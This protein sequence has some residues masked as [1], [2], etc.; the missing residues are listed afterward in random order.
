MSTISYFKLIHLIHS[1]LTCWVWMAEY[2]GLIY[3][4]VRMM[5][6]VKLGVGG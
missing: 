4:R 2:Y 1:K 3:G 6:R 5:E